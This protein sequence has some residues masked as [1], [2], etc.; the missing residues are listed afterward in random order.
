MI[1]D[2]RV[3]VYIVDERT[4]NKR[5]H[6]TL[7]NFACVHNVFERVVNNGFSKHYDDPAPTI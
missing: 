7:F 5:L 2:V 6:Y 1:C 4:G 3:S